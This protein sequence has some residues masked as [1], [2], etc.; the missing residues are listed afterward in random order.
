MDTSVLLKIYLDEEGSPAARAVLDSDAEMAAAAVAHVEMY[1]ALSRRRRDGT[2]NRGGLERI[3]HAFE[4]DWFQ[5]GKVNPDAAILRKAAKLCLRHP[6]R[7]LDAIQLSSALSIRD[8][9]DEPLVF[10]TADKRLEAAAKREKLV[11]HP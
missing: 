3:L 6:L 8:N 4:A 1:S 10:L 5:F 9:R 7:S 2:L 11:T